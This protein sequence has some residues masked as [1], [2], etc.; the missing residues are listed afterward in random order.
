MESTDVV[1]ESS[2]KIK[3]EE[4]VQSSG[5]LFA[6]RSQDDMSSGSPSETRNESMSEAEEDHSELVES[7]NDAKESVGT[8]RE[9]SNTT[10]EMS[11]VNSAGNQEARQE[12]IDPTPN[13]DLDIDEEADEPSQEEEEEKLNLIMAAH[14]E[15][16]EELMQALIRAK[17]LNVYR[18]DY[19]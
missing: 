9:I 8:T 3:E 11:I 7:P 2:T 14:L 15:S 12:L 19:K 4:L 13:K 16:N 17:Y 5:D 10:H 1:F 18:C 6:D